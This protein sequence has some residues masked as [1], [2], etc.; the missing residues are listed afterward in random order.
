MAELPEPR[1]SDVPT[2][3]YCEHQHS[4]RQS[5]LCSCE[6]CGEIFWV[7]VDTKYITYPIETKPEPEPKDDYGPDWTP[8]AC[9]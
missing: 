4:T 1:T 2:C 5:V 3:P 6:E 8:G 7:A 9:Y